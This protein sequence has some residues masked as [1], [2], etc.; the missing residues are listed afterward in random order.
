MTALYR[1]GGNT[2]IAER[3][4]KYFSDTDR[5]LANGRFST[6]EI[7]EFFKKRANFY[8]DQSSVFRYGLLPIYPLSRLLTR[9]GTNLI[10]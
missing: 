6:Q 3:E 5:D 4:L 2:A 7:D 1:A 9:T 8:T 10:S